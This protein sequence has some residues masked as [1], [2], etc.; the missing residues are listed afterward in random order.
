MQKEIRLTK[1]C[2]AIVDEDDFERLSRHNF[3]NPIDA[4][5]AYKQAAAGGIQ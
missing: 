4:A 5:A 2:V 1:G 3:R